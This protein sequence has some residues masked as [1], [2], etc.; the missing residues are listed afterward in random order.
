MKNSERLDVIEQRLE[1]INFELG[2]LCGSQKTTVI[3]IKFVILPLIFI[4][5]GLVGIRLW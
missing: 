3:L 5:A 4:V 1:K 2:E